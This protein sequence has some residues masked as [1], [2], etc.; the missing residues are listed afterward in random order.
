MLG[1]HFLFRLKK[2][3]KSPAMGFGFLLLMAYGYLT[4]GFIGSLHGHFM[5]A[6]WTFVLFVLAG[7]FMIIRDFKKVR[8]FF[9][10]KQWIVIF[11]LVDIMIFYA[12]DTKLGDLTA[13]G[14]VYYLNLISANIGTPSL[15][16]TDLYRG[17]FGTPLAPSYSM[18]AYYIFASCITYLVKPVVSLAGL[19]LNS[20]VIIW[21][22]QILY[23]FFF[24]SSLICFLDKVNDKRYL[25]MTVILFVF[26]FY[27]G[28][29][30]YNSVYGF[31]GNVFRM[32]CTAY[33]VM[34]L[35]DLIRENTKDNK[36]MFAVS[37]WGACAL[38][39]TSIFISLLLVFASF[40]VLSD[41][42]DDLFRFYAIVLFVPLA[43]FLL[44]LG[45]QNI[46]MSFTVSGVL[47]LTAFLLNDLLIRLS[48]KKL[49]RY[50]LLGTVFLAMLFLSYRVSGNVFDLDAFINNGSENNDA[51]INYFLLNDD[52][53]RNAFIILALSSALIAMVLKIR[54][55]LFMMFWILIIIFF[56]PACCSFIGHVF[57]A[58]FRAFD[59]IINPF[60]MALFLN[61]VFDVLKNKYF[62]Y[63][64]LSLILIVFYTN[65]RLG[66]P[67]YKDYTFEPRE[68]TY[69]HLAKMDKDEIDI[70]NK[71]M[72]LSGSYGIERPYII[73]D[74]F[75]T[76][77]NIPNAR[78][79]YG[80]DYLADETYSASDSYL[81][82][83]F[84]RNSTS[85]LEMKETDY[86]V[87]M[88]SIDAS[89][90]DFIVV[91]YPRS[92]EDYD[93]Y[94][95]I[96]YLTACSADSMVY[97]NDSYLLLMYEK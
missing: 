38:S 21:I 19:F 76:Q 15:N 94:N 26:V 23:D 22:F 9:D 50:V 32:F 53:S 65:I 79:L 14:P 84:R 40:F 80:R 8:W 95:L 92:Y 82:D 3:C 17:T 70:I 39:S 57:T 25:L 73:T 93:Y 35:D 89:G 18:Q 88:E 75:L 36:L 28:K 1:Q 49:F 47:C 85:D 43:D 4:V 29:L 71:I 87:L 41:M 44:N 10:C 67:A 78:F 11:I 31:C 77:S 91:D 20:E 52:V 16:M 5:L 54:Y 55:R 81:Y 51:S 30:Y 48:R 46:L 96:N 66:I 61:A 90:I 12:Y 37:V 45:L 69:D 34:Y 13:Y 56:N 64:V 86:D 83:V 62:Y 7:L 68:E 60:T 97:A 63:G 27:F 58:Y 74:N 42:D 33:S 6:L 72:E 59:I 2:E 24:V